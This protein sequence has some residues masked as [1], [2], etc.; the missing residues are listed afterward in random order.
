[1]EE[2]QAIVPAAPASVPSV[3]ES[4]PAAQPATI[5]PSPVEPAFESAV[6]SKHLP[7]LTSRDSRELQPGE[8]ERLTS[9][10]K[11]S[12]EWLNWLAA[13]H[14]LPVTDEDKPEPAPAELAEFGLNLPEIKSALNSLA[15]MYTGIEGVADAL[16]EVY[17]VSPETYTDIVSVV[18]AADPAFVIGVLEAQDA[19]PAGLFDPA[20]EIQLPSDLIRWIPQDLASTAKGLDPAL[21]YEWL[22][23]G[24][25]ALI[26]NLDRQAELNQL[27]AEERGRVDAEWGQALDRAQQQ[28]QA[29]LEALTEQSLNDHERFLSQ[30]K[31]TGDRQADDTLR[32]MVSAAAIGV[33]LADPKFLGLWQAVN[34]QLRNA[35]VWRVYGEFARADEW[36]RS[37]RGYAQRLDVR[38]RAEMRDQI[39]TLAPILKGVVEKQKPAEPPDPEPPKLKNGKTNDVWMAWMLRD[40]Q[41]KR[42]ASAAR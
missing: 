3:A 11:V 10:N 15:N 19:I 13:Q 23:R 41:R 42:A 27:V 24:Q 20:P 35:P 6:S 37:A 25:E 5:P 30:W 12:S 26:Y 2:S 40:Q 7:N 29:Q 21:L 38:L 33:V 9:D 39:K 22:S 32:A 16:S 17:A 31:P 8:P 14:S 34:I 18:V 4:L 1:M 36:E 28:G